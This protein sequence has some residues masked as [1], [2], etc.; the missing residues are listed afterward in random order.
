MILRENI[1]D[2]KT[3]MRA[4]RA[5]S[6]LFSQMYVHVQYGALTLES[7]EIHTTRQRGLDSMLAN[8]IER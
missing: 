2:N 6:T 1:S 4:T 8:T 7:S 3:T 5:T